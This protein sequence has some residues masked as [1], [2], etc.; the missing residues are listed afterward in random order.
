MDGPDEPGHDDYFFDGSAV[1]P[2]WV[3]LTSHREAT[4]A[5]DDK[6]YALWA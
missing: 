1:S 5:G 2:T 4:L 3:P 6:R